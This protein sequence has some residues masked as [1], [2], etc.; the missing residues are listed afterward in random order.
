[1]PAS[2]TAR[3][4]SAPRAA[5]SSIRAALSRRPRSPTAKLAREAAPE[6]VQASNTLMITADRSKTGNPLMVGGPQIG[7]FYPG[8]TW[9]IDMHAGDLQ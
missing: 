9:E 6:P 1:M 3:S 2:P 7:Y 4:R 5:R 8:F